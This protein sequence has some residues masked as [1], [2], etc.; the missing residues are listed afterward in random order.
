MRTSVRNRIGKRKSW[1]QV[2]STELKMD[3]AWAPIYLRL[4]PHTLQFTTAGRMVCSARK[5][6][7]STLA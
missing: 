1:S 2:T 5:L 7:A 3:W 4:Q 6:A